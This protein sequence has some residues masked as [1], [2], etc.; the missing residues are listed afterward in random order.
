MTKFNVIILSFSKFNAG[1]LSCRQYREV[2]LP[3]KYRSK[4]VYMWVRFSCYKIFLERLPSYLE[5][6]KAQLL[7][8]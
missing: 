7:S 2:A 6:F 8:S 1:T 5:H 3:I 4:A